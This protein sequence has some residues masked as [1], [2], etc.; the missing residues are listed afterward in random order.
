MSAMNKY[1]HLCLL[2]KH[3][4]IDYYCVTFRNQELI[5]DRGVVSIC[6]AVPIQ[7][8]SCHINCIIN[9]A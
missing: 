1:N 4:L 3:S 9:M 6:S 7:I 5:A 8:E 2:I